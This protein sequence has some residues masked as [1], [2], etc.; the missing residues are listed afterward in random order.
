MAARADDD[1]VV[2]RDAQVPGGLDDVAGELDIL[3]ARLR[4]AARMVVDDD[5]RGGVIIQGA[6]DNL[7]NIDRRFVH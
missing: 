5:D 3:A 6:A 1:V 7:A 2:D 4:I